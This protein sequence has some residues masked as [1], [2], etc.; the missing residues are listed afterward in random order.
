MEII[1]AELNPLVP[2]TL[3]YYNFSGLVY[4]K[5]FLLQKQGKIQYIEKNWNA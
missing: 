5:S 1:V 2:L 4:Y 3:W